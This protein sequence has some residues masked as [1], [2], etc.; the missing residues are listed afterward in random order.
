M[1]Q[2]MRILIVDDEE[3]I[4]EALGAWLVKDGYQV[5]TADS[6]QTALSCIEEGLFDLYL[7][8]IKMPGM[9]G[10]E[11]LGR[12]KEIQTDANV[13]MITAHGSIQTAVEA[14]KRG[15][16]D[17][18]CKPFDPDELSLMTERVSANQA[19]KNENL[20][21]REQLMEQQEN[22]YGRNVTT[23]PWLMSSPYK[24]R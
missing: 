11:L 3:P 21:L 18:I 9:G 24:T 16:C 17:Y 12:I 10:I 14:M 20:V 8:D 19:L 4:R 1:I 23:V 7:V 5:N 2:A 6:G 22:T 15:A 13:I